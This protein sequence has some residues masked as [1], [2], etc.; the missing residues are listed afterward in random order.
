MANQFK[1]YLAQT[2]QASQVHWS[3]HYICGSV[4]KIGADYGQDAICT[5]VGKTVFRQS[6]SRRYR[7]IFKVL[8]IDNDSLH[9]NNTL[10]TLLR[11][12]EGEEVEVMLVSEQKSPKVPTASL[13][14]DARQKLVR[15]SVIELEKNQLAAFLAGAGN[16]FDYAIVSR[17][18]PT[19]S[20][21]AILNNTLCPVITVS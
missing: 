9:L 8:I 5:I 2:A 3:Y 12:F 18:E 17:H 6:I 16:T 19:D 1:E 21:R 4:D 13:L 10:Q 11:K 20:L 14:Q 15:F 7:R